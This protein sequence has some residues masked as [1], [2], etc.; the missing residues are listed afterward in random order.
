MK[1]RPWLLA[2]ATLL[3]VIPSATFSAE[4]L[5]WGAQLHSGASACPSGPVVVNVVQK[6][7][8]S[9]DSGTAGNFWAFDDYIRHI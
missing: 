1:A 9:V 3:L 6:V 7:V 4:H 8:N 2:A 5:D